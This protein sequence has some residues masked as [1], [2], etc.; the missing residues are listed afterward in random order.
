MKE[1]IRMRVLE[2]AQLI[3]AT[4][5]TVRSAARKLGV[6]KSTVHKDMEERLRLLN[7]PL[8]ERV[9]AVL[10][11]NKAERHWRGGAATSAHYRMLRESA[12]AR[13]AAREG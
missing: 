6:S 10:E 9:R 11:K 2:G 8:Y 13:S 3:A 4:G 1:S 12:H 7:V 5:M